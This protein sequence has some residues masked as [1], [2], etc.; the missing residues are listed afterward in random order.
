MGEKLKAYWVMARKPQG[1][2]SFEG[3]GIDGRIILKWILKKYDGKTW[4][5]LIWL[6]VGTSGRPI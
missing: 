6:R 2:S 1:K 3:L 4:T 5:W